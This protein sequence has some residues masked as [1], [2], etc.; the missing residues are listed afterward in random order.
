MNMKRIITTVVGIPIVVAVFMFANIKILDIIV[1]LIAIRSIYEYSK[2]AKNTCNVISWLAYIPAIF[3]AFIHIIPVDLWMKILPMIIPVF[4]LFLFM[5]VI[6]TDGKTTYKDVA[7]TIAGVIYLISLI[8][9]LPL[10]YG[11]ENGKIYFWYV[12]LSSWGSDIFAYII[13]K[14]FGKHKF[15]KI[16]PNKTI[17]GCIAGLVGAVVLSLLYTVFVNKTYNLNMNYLYIAIICAI[18]GILGQ[19]GDFSASVVKRHFDVKDFSD[20]F[21]GHGGMIDR[22]DSIIFIAPFAYYSFIILL[23]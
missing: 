7:Y 9:F 21:P 18:L 22:I 6:I 10:L 5:K 4:L 3:I 14:H 15:S 13:G 8:I 1:S 17:E 16:S 2:C 11:K 23:G 19:V 20:L 12:I